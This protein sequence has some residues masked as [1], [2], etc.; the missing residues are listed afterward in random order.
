MKNVNGSRTRDDSGYG[1]DDENPF[2]PPVYY[3]ALIVV[4]GLIILATFL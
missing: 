4:F 2:V 3:V 1:G